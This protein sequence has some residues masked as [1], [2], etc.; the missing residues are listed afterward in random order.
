VIFSKVM[1]VQSLPPGK[2][3]LRAILS[4]AEGASVAT[5]TRGFE[6][7][8]PKVLLTSAEGLGSVSVDAELFLPIDEAVMKPVFQQDLAVEET[9]LAPFRE[10]VAPA[11]KAAFDQGVVFLAAG[12]WAKAELSFKK[13]IDPDADSTSSLTFLAASFAAAGKDREAAS[14]WQTALVDGTD[15]PQLYAWLADALLRTHDFGAARAILEEAAAKW[16]T[17][18]RFTKPLAMLYGT[19][20]RGRE[21]VRTLERYLDDRQDDRDA[22]FYAV[23]WI[24]TVHAGGAV[25][26]TRAEDRK[27]AHDYA[28]AYLRARG[29]QSALVKQWIDYLDTEK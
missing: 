24:Y 18:T 4:S 17:D 25:V 6:I 27:R 21:A 23:Q 26:H 2:Y 22:H 29:P 20:G 9:T 15:F 14:A 11:V 5:L 1:P 12:D 8:P 16:P 13:A 19:F 3:L 7:A 10:R 28:D